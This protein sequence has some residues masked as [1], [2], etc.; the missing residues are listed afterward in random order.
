MQDDSNG[1][2]GER[3][4]RCGGILK[5]S[6]EAHTHINTNPRAR[7]LSPL[8]CC[9][10][11]TDGMLAISLCVFLFARVEKQIPY[12]LVNFSLYLYFS[13]VWLSVSTASLFL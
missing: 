8:A 1:G 7:S 11:V 10:A 3:G 9:A 6:G 4:N 13:Q 5:A 12:P 2:K